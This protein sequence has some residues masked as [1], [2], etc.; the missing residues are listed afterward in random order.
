MVKE[1]NPYA[2]M[3]RHVADMIWQNSIEDIQLVLIGTGKQLTHGA[4]MYQLG[5]TKLC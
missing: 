2:K 4:I 5:L 3:Y 1:V